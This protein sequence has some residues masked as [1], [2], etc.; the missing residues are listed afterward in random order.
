MQSKAFAGQIPGF[1][2]LPCQQAENPYGRHQLTGS[3]PTHKS[4]SV[5]LWQKAGIFSTMTATPLLLGWIPSARF[6]L[7]SAATPSRK[8]G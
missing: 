3:D 7:C 8:N 1:Y 4:Y 6:R 5:T 2:Q